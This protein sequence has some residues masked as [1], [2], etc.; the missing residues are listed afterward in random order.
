MN[1]PSVQDYLRLLYV[2]APTLSSAN[3]E[4][5]GSDVMREGNPAD[6]SE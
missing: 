3:C 1:A 6:A 5:N 2:F 4:K